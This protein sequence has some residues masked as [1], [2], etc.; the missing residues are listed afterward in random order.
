MFFDLKLKSLLP[1]FYQAA[2]NF[3]SDLASLLASPLDQLETQQVNEHLCTL[4]SFS[5]IQGKYY[6]QVW[7]P[8]LLS[9]LQAH[10]W[11]QLD[12]CAS[13]ELLFPVQCLELVR[14]PHIAL[15]VAWTGTL[16]WATMCLSYKLGILLYRK[17]LEAINCLAHMFCF[18][19]TILINKCCWLNTMNR[20]KSLTQL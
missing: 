7:A 5:D 17:N 2:L 8:L 16:F 13:L 15:T 12:L 19:S 18:L 14:W 10:K 20:T 9:G 11:Q 1:V 4:V 3:P 6:L